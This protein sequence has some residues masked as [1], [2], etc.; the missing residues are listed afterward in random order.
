M[1]Y[2]EKIRKFL[3]LNSIAVLGYSRDT[4][5]PANM[6]YRKLNE[7]GYRVVAVNP[8]ANQIKDIRCYPDIKS[9]PIKVQ[10]AIICTPSRITKDAVRQCAEHGINHI[11]IHKGLGAGSYD[12]EAHQTGKELG[13][14]VI[15]GCCP[16]MFVEPDIVHRCLGWLQKLPE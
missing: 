15:P 5:Q 7:N 16:M 14:E 12:P 1:G 8:R 6:I 2:K 10:G 13:L 3:E 11:W 4:N 9:L